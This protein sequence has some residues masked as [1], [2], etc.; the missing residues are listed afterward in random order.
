MFFL[1]FLIHQKAFE[2]LLKANNNIQFNE[3]WKK[4]SR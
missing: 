1:F 3:K 4:Q 2:F